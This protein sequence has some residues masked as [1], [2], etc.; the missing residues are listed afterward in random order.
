MQLQPRRVRASSVV[1]V[2]LLLIA[3]CSRASSTSGDAGVA[4]SSTPPATSG[5]GTPIDPARA[6]AVPAEGAAAPSAR[7]PTTYPP[8]AASARQHVTVASGAKPTGLDHFEGNALSGM[9][10]RN[11]L[12]PLAKSGA[13][14]AP[15]FF[16]G[17]CVLLTE[18]DPSTAC[19][20]YAGG[21]KA[22]AWASG[23]AGGLGHAAECL[24]LILDASPAR[25]KLL[26]L[27]KSEE[28]CRECFFNARCQLLVEGSTAEPCCD[29]AH[30]KTAGGWSDDREAATC[31]AREAHKP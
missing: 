13:R 12:M 6:L 28:P 29:Y 30:G 16:N 9:P 8:P 11:Q 31:L 24:A 4:I 3:A 23:G 25:A 19:C 5:V 18:G 26:P 20:D 17:R 2:L 21:K 15:C 27:A 22:D 10:A 14:C 1:A 7:T